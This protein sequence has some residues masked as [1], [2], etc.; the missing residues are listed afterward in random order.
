MKFKISRPGP[1][2]NALL[3]TI[4]ITIFWLVWLELAFALP[5]DNRRNFSPSEIGGAELAVQEPCY[6][7]GAMTGVCRRGR[8]L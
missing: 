2:C 6:P 8:L 4:G 3:C 7:R 1:H 5:S